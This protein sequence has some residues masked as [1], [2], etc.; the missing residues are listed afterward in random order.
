[1][2]L[3]NF[4]DQAKDFYREKREK[5]AENACVDHLIKDPATKRALDA[6]M[7]KEPLDKD[8][9]EQLTQGLTWLEAHRLVMANDNGK[10]PYRPA[11]RGVRVFHRI[12]DVP[13][14]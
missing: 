7:Q 4:W 5:A 14:P 2:N 1:M 8:S 13:Q 9:V 11:L 12:N 10:Y 6:V 3:I